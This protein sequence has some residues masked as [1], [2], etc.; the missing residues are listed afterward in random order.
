M[1]WWQNQD[2]VAQVLYG[3]AIWLAVF[4]IVGKI[5]SAIRKRNLQQ[6]VNAPLTEVRR[7][8]YEKG[9]TVVIDGHDFDE[10]TFKDCTLFYNGGPCKVGR[11][12]LERPKGTM[13]GFVTTNISVSRTLSVLHSFKLMNLQVLAAIPLDRSNDS[14][15]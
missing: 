3:I 8:T 13:Y 14:N 7:R 11:N 5:W 12:K 1:E 4:G 15:R 2:P 10:C 6:D 9:E